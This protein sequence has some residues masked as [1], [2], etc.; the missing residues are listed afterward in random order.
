MHV[1]VVGSGGR[2]HALVWKLSQSAVVSKITCAP[3]NVGLALVEKCKT[4]P[5]SVSDFD[6]LIQFARSNDV[7]LAVIGPEVPLVA[8]IADAFEAAGIKV[9]GPTKDGAQ[10]EGSKSWSKQL[11]DDAGVPTAKSQTFTAAAEAINYL[12]QQS[13][14][15]VVK[16]DG[17]A[18]GKGVTVAA[19]IQEAIDAVTD[20]FS[21]TLGEAGNTVVIEDF[22]VG[23]EASV[24]AFTD[25][26]TILPMI[27]AQDHKQVGEGDTGPNTGGMG[28]YAP[29][30]I[31]TP[32]VMEQVRQQVLEPTLK[33]LRDRGITYKGVLYAGL[34]IS[35]DGQPSVVEFNCRFGDPETQVVLPLFKSDLATVMLAC[36]EGKLHEINLEWHEGYAACVVMASGGYPGAYET[37]KPIRGLDSADEKAVIFQAGTKAG[38]SGE[39]VTNGGRVLGITGQGTSLQE[40]LDAA[41]QSIAHIQFEGAYFRSDIGFRVLGNR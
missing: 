14:P 7:E 31:V 5:L 21:G 23:Q 2:E 25:S 3:G 28:A 15:I 32:E 6:G 38:E 13:A 36:A 41:Y 11:M 27:A 40:A 12:N 4:L 19:T 30:P 35:P 22:L 24:L 29:T 37:G 17:L 8:G 20:L 1:L 9:F 18:A 33:T 10:L 39:I 16:A 34:M 26:Q